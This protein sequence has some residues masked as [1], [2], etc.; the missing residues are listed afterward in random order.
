MDIPKLESS[1]SIGAI[2]TQQ[3]VLNGGHYDINFSQINQ[4]FAPLVEGPRRCSDI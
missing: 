2:A 4:N 1:G 3:N